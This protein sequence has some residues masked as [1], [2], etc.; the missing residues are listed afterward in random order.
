MK[1]YRRLLII[2]KP[3]WN[4]RRQTKSLWHSATNAWRAVFR[5]L[6]R[7]VPRF[8]ILLIYSASGAYALSQWPIASA[9]LGLKRPV[10]IFLTTLFLLW[11]LMFLVWTNEQ[12]QEWVLRWGPAL[13]AAPLW[14]G[15]FVISCAVLAVLTILLMAVYLVVMPVGVLAM[16]FGI[17]YSWWRKHHGITMRC[18][19]GDCKTA[20]RP[21]RDIEVCY[22]CDCGHQGRFFANP[23]HYSRRWAFNR[24][25]LLYED[26]RGADA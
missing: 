6:S 17:F 5:F 19:R 2:E 13:L 3:F 24:Q 14:I 26:G 9:W 16:I 18:S 23:F 20:K 22:V 21:F 12:V 25:N 1:G 15:P 7:D 8:T 4:F 11:A 10:D